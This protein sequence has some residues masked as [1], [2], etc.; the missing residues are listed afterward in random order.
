MDKKKLFII[1][2]FM[3]KPSDHWFP[4]LKCKAEKQNIDVIIPELPSPE[5][6]VL[7]EWLAVLRDSVGKID[8]KTWFVAHSLG[9]MTILRLL[10]QLTV[11]E[12]PAGIILVSGFNE[13]LPV[14]RQHGLSEMDAFIYPP[15]EMGQIV[16]GV[17]H[18]YVIGSLNDTIVPTELTLKLS[19]QLN[20]PF[21][22]LPDSGHFLGD[23]GIN[24]LPLVLQLLT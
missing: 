7:S 19:Q 11:N 23:D 5:S 2:G 8:N 20:A 22:A 15:L 4:W 17:K 3:A 16:N 6:P 13:T 1:H 21:Y 18:R 14:W 10:A 24:E 12:M 9:C